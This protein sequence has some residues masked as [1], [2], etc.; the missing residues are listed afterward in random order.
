MGR[1]RELVRGG[2]AADL[3]RLAEAV[4]A[5]EIGHQVA[6]G[7]SLDEVTELEAR[8]V[9]LAGGHRDVDAAGHLRAGGQVVGQHRLLVPHEVQV[10]QEPRLAKVAEHVE[11]LVDVHHEPDPVA[12][13]LLH[14]Q[15]ALPVG[16]RIGVVDLEL[17]VAA[18]PRHVGLG[19]ADQVV[20]RVARPSAAAVGGDPVGDPAPE[21]V[22]R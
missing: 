20:E 4:G 12:H 1:D 22:E 15:H 13:R 21:L 7:A 17:V 16:P 10:F 19:F 11:L 6:G 5:A 9:V 3:E 2:E 14:R 8:V 18:A